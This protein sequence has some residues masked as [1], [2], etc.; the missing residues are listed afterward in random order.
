MLLLGELYLEQEP[1][2]QTVQR[3][4]DLVVPSRVGH[5]AEELLRFSTEQTRAQL[6]LP[7]RVGLETS[8]VL[9]EQEPLAS[10]RLVRIKLSGTVA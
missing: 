4:L 5:L 3:G 6:L 1:S 7:Q 10:S 2:L 9:V 8:R